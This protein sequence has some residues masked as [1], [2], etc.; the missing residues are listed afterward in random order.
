MNSSKISSKRLG[1][2]LATATMTAIVNASRL[3]RQGR[4]RAKRRGK[5]L[6]SER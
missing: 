1:M 6:G 5:A 3:S 2:V 4:P